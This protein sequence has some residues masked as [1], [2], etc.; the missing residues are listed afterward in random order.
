MEPASRITRQ[1]E[2]LIQF[3]VGQNLS[4]ARLAEAS[5]TAETRPARKSPAP[6]WPEKMRERAETLPVDIWYI[7]PIICKVS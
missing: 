6:Q 4:A 7:Y 5:W 1:R 3:I 2:F